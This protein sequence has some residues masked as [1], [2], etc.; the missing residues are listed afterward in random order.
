[1]DYHTNPWWTVKTNKGRIDAVIVDK[2][3]YVFE[4]KFDG[5][6][7]K[8][9]KQIKDKQYFEKYQGQR[10]KYICL[11]LILVTE[12]WVNGWLRRYSSID[13]DNAYTVL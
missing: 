2:D 6:K 5:D 11:V 9:L 8:A 10:K 4:F 3:I 7:D 13:I 1:M 12:M